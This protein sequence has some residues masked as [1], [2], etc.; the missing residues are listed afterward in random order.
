MTAFFVVLA[1]IV[2]AFLWRSSWK[3]LTA[4]F[5][6]RYARYRN[7]RMIIRVFSELADLPLQVRSR[8]SV[9]EPPE[10][11]PVRAIAT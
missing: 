7:V 11:T 2:P 10:R 9:P 3:L 6:E 8:I 1:G 5:G 4:T